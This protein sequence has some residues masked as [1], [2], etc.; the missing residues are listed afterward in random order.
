MGLGI[1]IPRNALSAG[2]EAF[3]NNP[4]GGDNVALD[5]GEYLGLIKG[6]KG[7]ET[8]KGP[9]IVCDISVGGEDV[10]SSVKGGTVSL[11]FS[12]EE[13]RVVFL[14]KFLAL[15]GYQDK[16]EDLDA[17]TLDEIANELPGRNIIVKFRATEKD[18]YTNLRL[19]KVM[20]DLTPEEIGLEENA[21]KKGKGKAKAKA[22]ADEDEDEP[23]PKAKAKAK[24]KASDDDDDEDET[25]EEK[26]KAK[27]KEKAKAGAD[28]DETVDDEDDTVEVKVGLIT[29]A[30]IKGEERSV[31]VKK[32]LAEEGKIIVQDL[33]SDE[34]F[35]ISPDRLG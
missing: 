16:I 3:Q 11:W 13:D 23:A 25:A 10:D 24:V 18:G 28:E 21:T 32:I 22:D 26:P 5:P 29:N 1:K 15:L 12:F 17:A 31:K 27:G 9:Q 33:E 14:F 2:R 7:V 34:K 6:I 8:A 20:E 35:K 4:N 19:K 30:T